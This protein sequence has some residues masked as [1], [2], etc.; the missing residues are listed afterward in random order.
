[1]N[2]SLRVEPG[3]PSI[4]A[5]IQMR[6]EAGWGLVSHK[7]A[8]T[9]LD[10][11]LYGVCLYDQQS[12]IG[13]ARLVGDGVL[14]F[15]IADIVISPTHKGQGHG[16]LLM[17]AIMKYINANA[18]TGATVALLPAPGLEGFYSQFGFTPCPN[19]LFGQG[20]SL[21]VGHAGD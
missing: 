20:L 13:F 21:I 16:S 17:A 1:M 18:Q 2:N 7:T 6:E 15:Y 12:L 8:A 14:Y 5:Y 4:T 10:G 11:S 19:Q 9:C 3:L